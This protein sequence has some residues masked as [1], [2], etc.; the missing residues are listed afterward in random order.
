MSKIYLSRLAHPALLQYLQSCGHQVIPVGPIAGVEPAIQTHA[1]LLHCSLGPALTVFHGDPTRLSPRYPGDAVYNACVTG[2]YFIHNLKYTDP[3]LL[4][5]TKS[6]GLT[7]I[8]V[9]Q[10]Y[11]RCSCLPVACDA[12]I[13]ADQGIAGPC[14]RA[15]LAVLTI[16]PGYVN[17]PGYP[18][19]FLGGA[20]GRVGNEILFHGNLAAHPDGPA[21][22]RFIQDHGLTCVDFSDLRARAPETTGLSETAGIMPVPPDFPLTDIGSIIE[23]V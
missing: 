22:R 23:E 17:L 15:G 8:D 1:D 18:Y 7:F 2:K 6:M 4:H 13:T 9:P 19:G 16:R 5:L 3:A 20:A 14:R 12:I 10:G 11:A 21:I